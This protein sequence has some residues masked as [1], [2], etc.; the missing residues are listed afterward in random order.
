MADH[1]VTRNAERNRFETVVDGHTAFLDYEL[2]DNR[3]VLIHTDVPDE[4]EGQGVGTAIVRAALAY[5]RE[6]DIVVEPQS[7]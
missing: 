7:S 2:T 6:N 5:A 4:L 3:I 1:V